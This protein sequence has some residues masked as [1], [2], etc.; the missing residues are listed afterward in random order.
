MLIVFLTPLVDRE[1]KKIKFL[2]DG[3]YELEIGNKNKTIDFSEII[4]TFNILGQENYYQRILLC[5]DKTNFQTIDKKE[6][7]IID[8]I[9][10]EIKNILPIIKKRGRE[11][12]K[13]KISTLE[14]FKIPEEIYGLL[15]YK[16]EIQHYLGKVIINREKRFDINKERKSEEIFLK[17][18]TDVLASKSIKKILEELRSIRNNVEHYYLDDESEILKL[19]HFSKLVIWDFLKNY[20]EKDPL[21]ELDDETKKLFL[22]YDKVRDKIIS[23]NSDKLKEYFKIN[24]KKFYIDELSEEN[25]YCPKCDEQLLVEDHEI[26]CLGCGEFWGVEK[27]FRKIEDNRIE[28]LRDKVFEDFEI[29]D[30]DIVDYELNCP[31][32]RKKLV[33]T[34][35]GNLFCKN[36][37]KE[38]DIRE[39][40]L[41]QRNI[42]EC[43]NCHMIVPRSFQ[44]NEICY[45][46]FND[47]MEKD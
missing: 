21:L 26:K 1:P 30:I 42:I 23:D 14:S 15:K 3:K 43:H 11:D 20:L 47:F 31:E 27:Y 18:K 6:K 12:L 37:D 16:F 44:E 41:E 46:C 7:E 4:E 32:C 17:Y 36:C 5:D 10:S 19:I 22:K 13:D 28:S 33:V 25:F 35:D 45:S 29:D 9:I 24:G 38:L 39:F 40:L 34:I 2:G 8:I